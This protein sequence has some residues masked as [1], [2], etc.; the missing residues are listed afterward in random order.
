MALAPHYVIDPNREWIEC[1]KCGM[2]SYNQFDVQ[3]RYCSKCDLFL[4]ECPD[5]SKSDDD[6]NSET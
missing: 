5:W 1:G 4:D 2:R 6:R 3:L